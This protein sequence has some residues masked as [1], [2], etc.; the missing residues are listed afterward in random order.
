MNLPILRFSQPGHLLL[1]QHCRNPPFWPIR[2]RSLRMWRNL[3][4]SDAFWRRSY[5]IRKAEVNISQRPGLY[6]LEGQLVKLHGRK[7]MVAM[8]YSTLNHQSKINFD[9]TLGVQ[10]HCNENINHFDR[11]ISRARLIYWVHFSHEEWIPLKPWFF[12]LLL[13]NSLNWKINCE[14]HTSL[15]STIAVQ[16]W[17]VSYIYFTSFHSSREKWT[18]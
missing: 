15:S 4:T 1:E 8:Q 17:I 11:I 14:D 16:I 9:S 5:A 12:R 6:I 18:Q 10:V 2:S 13:S 7:H 3:L